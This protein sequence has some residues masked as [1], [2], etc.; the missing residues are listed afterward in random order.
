MTIQAH[1]LRARVSSS[2]S[3]WDQLRGMGGSLHVRTDLRT[4]S[5]GPTVVASG[6]GSAGSTLAVRPKM[7]PQAILQLAAL[8]GAGPS[9]QGQD[10]LALPMQSCLGAAAGFPMPAHAGPSP[11]ESPSRIART[12]R[13]DLMCKPRPCA[14][15][16]MRPE[17][18][19]QKAHQ[20][21]GSRRFGWR[22]PDTRSVVAIALPPVRASNPA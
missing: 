12:M 16:H 6:L 11:S 17:I 2:A 4:G 21:L 15:M 22:V 20:L 8:H 14:T 18:R 5:A 19:Q 10:P 1:A 9:S 13:N 7:L 3:R